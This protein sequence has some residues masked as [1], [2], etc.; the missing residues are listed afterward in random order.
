M[1]CFGP[2]FARLALVRPRVCIR[3]SVP[4]IRTYSGMVET[5]SQQAT[6]RTPPVYFSTFDVKDQVFYENETAVALVN[7]K[8][9]VPGHVLVIPKMQYERLQDIPASDL[10][11]LFSAVQSVGKVVESAFSGDSLSVAVQDGPNAGQTVPHVHV[12]VI[13][14]RA[15][16]IEPNDLI[17][18]HLDAFGLQL[19][20]LQEKQMDSE[21]RPRTKEQMHAE[22]EWLHAQ[23]VRILGE[24][25]GPV[26]LGA[27]T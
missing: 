17:Y 25:K 3:P 7:L 10:G 14:R 21:R 2:R 8:P 26:R 4:W 24:T 6:L 15:R 16:D 20:T 18:E 1:R 27:A 5:S 9:V 19:R 11:S 13:P 12:H 23:C 22:A